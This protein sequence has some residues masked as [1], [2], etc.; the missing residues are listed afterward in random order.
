MKRF[1]L[2][3][4]FLLLL[5]SGAALAH[6]GHGDG[7]AAG[8]AHPYSGLDH[9]LAM[10]AVGLWAAQQSA[11]DALWK[12]PLSFVSVMAV[13]ALLGMAGLALPQ[14]ET[15]IATSVVILG[16]LVAFSLRLP[17]GF[18][19][20]LVAA[21][22]LFHGFAHGVEA[23]LGSLSIFATGFILATASLH[24]LGMTLGWAA[25]HR[26]EMALRAGGAGVALAGAWLALG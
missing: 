5:S 14:V 13:G 15:G 12:I 17:T 1:T 2:P 21:F 20:T 7:L 9:L 25:R 24:G 26:A 3:A 16:L 11:K 19:M 10:V 23:P 22:A 4:A 8:L 18:G 6:P